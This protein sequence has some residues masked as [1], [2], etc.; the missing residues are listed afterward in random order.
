MPQS[1]AVAQALDLARA[2][3]VLR[4]VF[5]TRTS[6]EWFERLTEQKHP[7]V[8]VPTT[9][10]LMQQAVHRERGAF[11]EVEDGTEEQA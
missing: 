4:E 3:A 2:R 11:V 10:Q 1:A 6:A 8:I 5:P 9:E 7:A